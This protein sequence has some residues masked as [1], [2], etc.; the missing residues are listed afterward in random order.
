MTRGNWEL[1]VSSAIITTYIIWAIWLTIALTFVFYFATVGMHVATTL[2]L[3]MEDPD[4]PFV[5]GEELHVDGGRT[6]AGLVAAGTRDV[7]L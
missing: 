5:T 7:A 1:A 3:I 6:L 4:A 2:A